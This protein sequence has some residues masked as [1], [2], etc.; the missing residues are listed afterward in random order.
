MIPDDSHMIVKACA[1]FRTTRDSLIV[2]VLKE[3]IHTGFQSYILIFIK[4]LK[5]K[6]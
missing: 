6:R 1:A 3:F 4:C 5:H 2:D